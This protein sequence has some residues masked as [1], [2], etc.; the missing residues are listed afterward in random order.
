MVAFTA[1]YFQVTFVFTNQVNGRLVPVE[2]IMS[3]KLQ[4]KDPKKELLKSKQNGKQ[5]PTPFSLHNRLPL[6]SASVGITK[7][8]SMNVAFKP[9]YSLVSK[10]LP[11]KRSCPANINDDN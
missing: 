7:N 9:Q 6:Q 1:L 5:K 2:S 11:Q 10:V 4:Q 8:I 3:P